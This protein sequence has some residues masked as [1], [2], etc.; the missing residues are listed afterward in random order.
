MDGRTTTQK[1][2]RY[3]ASGM[4]SLRTS[5]I[6]LEFLPGLLHD[7]ATVSALDLAPYGY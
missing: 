1:V 7:A 3:M 6:E 4:A 5:G 2:K